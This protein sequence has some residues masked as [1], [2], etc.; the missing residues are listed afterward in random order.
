MDFY[1]AFFLGLTFSNIWICALVIFSLQTS[2]KRTGIGY[3]AGRFA[4]IVGLVL[5]FH[6]M[7]ENIRISS[8]V[9]DAFSGLTILIFGFYFIFKYK[10]LYDKGKNSVS[11]R[12]LSEKC[13]HNCNSCIISKKPDIY[14]YCESLSLIHI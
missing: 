12:D 8:V 10:N 4:G 3:I 1:T 11:H 7:G 6:I 2:D 5:I 9:I 14:K 13:E